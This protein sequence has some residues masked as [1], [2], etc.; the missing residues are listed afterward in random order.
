MFVIIRVGNEKMN[1]NFIQLIRKH[2]I[3]QYQLAH[4]TG[5]PFAT[6][7]GLVLQTHD[8]NRCAAPTLVKLSDFFKTDIEELLNPFPIMDRV[9][10][11]YKDI[12]YIWKTNDNELMEIHLL[13]KYKGVVLDVG[14][15]CNLLSRKHLY[16]LIAEMLIDAY[17]KQCENEQR[18][19]DI[20]NARQIIHTHA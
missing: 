10:G 4:A 6:I 12:K 11:Q 15:R 14:Y 16:P 2:N 5:I 13:G 7:N 19:E 8:I 3:T 9:Q 1:E 20:I 18:I 17:L